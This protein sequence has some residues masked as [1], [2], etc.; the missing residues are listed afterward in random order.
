[1]REMRVV[2]VEPSEDAYGALLSAFTRKYGPEG[3]WSVLRRMKAQMKI[4]QEKEDDYGPVFQAM[5]IRPARNWNKSLVTKKICHLASQ[6][7]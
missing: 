6:S 2:G 5:I 3:G 4:Q 7:Q 1:M